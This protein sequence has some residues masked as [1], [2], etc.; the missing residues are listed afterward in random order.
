MSKKNFI[1]KII[2]ILFLV[3]FCSIAASAQ[4]KNDI[5]VK[6]EVLLEKAKLKSHKLLASYSNMQASKFAWKKQSMF[7]NPKFGFAYNNSPLKTFPALDE[8]AMSGMVLSVSQ[9]IYFPWESSSRKRESYWR[10]MSA[11]QKT[12]EVERTLEM[13]VRISYHRYGFFVLQKKLLMKSETA[14]KNIAASARGLVAAN[15]M[16]S[17]QL[18]KLEADIN[19]VA[20]LVLNVDSNMVQAKNK[21]ESLLGFDSKIID[22]DF[23]NY[24]QTLKIKKNGFRFKIKQHPL[25]KVFDNRAKAATAAYGLSK[26]KTLPAVT[27]SGAYTIR[28][29]LASGGTGDDFISLKA[30]MPIP[31]F[32][33]LKNTHQISQKKL[34]LV[35]TIE[36]TKQVELNLS[37]MWKSVKKQYQNLLKSASHYRTKVN[38]MAF[39]SYKAQLGAFASGTVKLLD[40]L[41]AYRFY[42]KSNIDYQKVRMQ[43]FKAHAQIIYFVGDK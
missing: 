26:A 42:L 22:E 35:T 3:L 39:A 36:M 40:V 16:S 37:T 2:S 30:A 9:K 38:P 14:L 4:K 25:V 17:A 31:L 24:W 28:Q 5:T 18:L 43:L 6:L 1:G 13:Q 33:G 19:K 15:K 10:Y 21:L 7:E 29:P 41:D 12:A 23:G 34:Q 20:T 32:Y 8:T 11:R 27:F